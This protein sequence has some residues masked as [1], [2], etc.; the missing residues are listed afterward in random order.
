MS[1]HRQATPDEIA[2]AAIAAA[3]AGTS[4]AHLHARDSNKGRLT[5]DPSLFHRFLPKIK[6]AMDVAIY[7]TTGGAAA[8]T[9]EERLRPAR[10]NRFHSK[11]RRP[12][13]HGLCS[14]CTAAESLIICLDN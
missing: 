7:I 9:L 14:G 4:N 8:M 3:R 5:Q 10:S 6:E 2:D 1:P 13:K 11:S 12:M